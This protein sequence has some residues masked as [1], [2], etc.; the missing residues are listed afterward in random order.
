MEKLSGKLLI[1]DYYQYFNYPMRRQIMYLFKKGEMVRLEGLLIGIIPDGKMARIKKDIHCITIFDKRY[2]KLLLE[3]YDPP[4]VLYCKG[5]IDL[6]N[7]NKKI[8]MVGSREPKKES[9]T[10]TNNIISQLYQEADEEIVIVSGL[11]KG[12]DGYAHH[13]ALEYK[14]GTIAVLGFGFDYLYPAENKGLY[15]KI[16]EQGLVITEYPP[17]IGVKKWQFV[18]RNRIISGL[19]KAVIIIEAKAKSGSLI[20]AELALSE[21]REVF[22]VG[23]N[24]FD[25]SYYGSNSLVQEG[26]KL[27]LSVEEVLAEYTFEN[28]EEAEV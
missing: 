4:L 28:S 17:H 7:Y 3:S 16:R 5:N 1:G 22:I 9:L 20:T 27:L 15:D 2:P 10:A 12:I 24:S 11:A 25:T 23:G 8:A 21:N 19:C 13:L 14:I 26:A 6:L 18:A